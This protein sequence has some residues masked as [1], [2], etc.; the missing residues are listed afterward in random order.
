M[1]NFGPFFKGSLCIYLFIFLSFVIFVNSHWS[2]T[3]STEIP[4]AASTD[5]FRPHR[6]PLIHRR[7]E[8]FRA[9][10]PPGLVGPQP[11]AANRTSFKSPLIPSPLPSLSQFIS[12][13]RLLSGLFTIAAWATR[14]FASRCTTGTEI[15]SHALPPMRVE[16]AEWHS[17]EGECEQRSC[18]S[19]TPGS[20]NHPR[21]EH[22]V[23]HGC[24]GSTVF[25]FLLLPFFSPLP[26]WII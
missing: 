1:V 3:L 10:S 17:S 4:D 24:C 22:P 19:G 13:R 14:L 20:T 6:D 25:F 16:T 9:S 5:W 21:R 8:C 7:S 18:D 2:I 15:P 11:P 26:S 23:S 12:G